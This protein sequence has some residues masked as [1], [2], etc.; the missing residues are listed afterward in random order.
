MAEF[1]TDREGIKA[2]RETDDYK[3]I[4][5]EAYKYHKTHGTMQ[6]F[7][8]GADL[9]IKFRPKNVVNYDKQT[10]LGSDPIA[11]RKAEGKA[12]LEKIKKQTV[13]K[14]DLPKTDTAAIEV[15]HQRMVDLYDNLYEGLDDADSAK[16]SQFFSEDLNMP[17]GDKYANAAFLP[18]KPHDKVHKFIDNEVLEGLPD[19]NSPKY[20][21]VELPDG[22]ILKGLDARKFHAKNFFGDLVQPAI[23]ESTMGFMQDFAKNNPKGYGHLF[24]DT[25]NEIVNS[26]IAKNVSK[27]A[28]KTRRADLV[29][30]IGTGVAT[31]NVVQAGAGVAG[32]TASE[33]L[34]SPASQKAISKQIAK[35]AAKRGGKSALK[36]IPGLDVLISGKEAYDYLAQGKFDQAGIAALSG[37]IG[38]IPVIGDGASAALDLT[39]TGIDISRLDLSGTS[40]VKTKKTKKP[41]NKLLR[42]GKSLT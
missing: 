14:R 22:R 19:F 10:G 23:D 31:G 21:T 4:L 15:H 40:D 29:A 42:I 24:R 6:G 13:G 32:L 5:A 16:L 34:Q 7:D 26:K 3:K 8:G 27:A 30:Q 20:N 9:G 41:K 35:L 36:L 39:N 25:V 28:G 11:S 17:L 1:I 37:A 12:R 38:W 2:F 18:K 33:A